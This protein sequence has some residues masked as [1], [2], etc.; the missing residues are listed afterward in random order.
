MGQQHHMAHKRM[1]QAS[2]R[3]L[4]LSDGILNSLL[5]GS[6]VVLVLFLLG[7]DEVLVLLFLS[8]HEFLALLLGL[9]EGLLLGL[10]DFANLLG[11]H[12]VWA[13]WV[14]ARVAIAGVAIRARVAIAACVSVWEEA[15]CGVG[16]PH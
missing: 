9:S 15:H 11:G 3:V 4:L 12:A 7:G 5:L 13:V 1:G 14:G 16:V 8:L 10:T 2:R 6:N